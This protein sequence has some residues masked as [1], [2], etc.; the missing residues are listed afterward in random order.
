MASLVERTFLDSKRVLIKVGSSTLVDLKTGQVRQEWLES[1]IEDVADLKQQGKDVLLVSS[2]AVYLGSRMLGKS[3]RVKDSIAQQQ[4]AASVGLVALADSWRL[5]MERFS[6]KAGL[7]LLTIDDTEERKRHLNV[8]GSLQALLQ[9]GVV[10]LINENDPVTTKRLR[11]GDNDRLAARIATMVGVDTMVILSDVDGL[12]TGD[13]H[14]PGAEHIPVVEEVTSDIEAI[15]GGP[16]GR[17]AKGGMQSKVSAA[18]FCMEG[19]CSLILCKG[20]VKRPLHQLLSGAR[21]TLFL[22]SVKAHTAREKWLIGM[23]NYKGS[24]EI[25]DGAA[26]ALKKGNSLLP[27][28]IV[29]CSGN[30]ARGDVVQVFD[31]MQ[32]RLAVGLCNY[33]AGEVSQV[34]GKQSRE[35]KDILGYIHTPEIMHRDD[36]AIMRGNISK[37][38]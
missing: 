37:G 27:S 18:K 16:K 1:L 13:P 34:M 3:D 14:A 12:Y 22:S 31:R 24:V 19:G 17:H 28:G 25:D 5:A 30:F 26:V 9:Q 32:K 20:A 7:V 8:R 21:H 4:A 36:M 35:I 33:D 38:L 15:A 2:G 6:L 23:L 29:A 11:F 10:P